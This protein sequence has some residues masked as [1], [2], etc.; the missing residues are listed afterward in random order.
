MTN[1]FSKV[2]RQRLDTCDTRLQKVMEAVLQ[3]VNISIAC[4]HRSKE[5]QDKAFKG[6]FSKLRFPK[7]KHNSNPSVAVD[8]IPYPSGYQ[9]TEKEWQDLAKV[10]KEE[11]AK[12]GVEIVWGGDWKK[13]VDKPHFELKGA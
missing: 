13:F 3:R 4:G 10:V 12:L 1:V 7:S 6:G 5:E 2:S 8:I 9:A 11:A